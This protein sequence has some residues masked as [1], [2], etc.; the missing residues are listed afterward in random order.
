MEDWKKCWTPQEWAAI[1]G[2][3]PE[4]TAQIREATYADRPL[5]PVHR[6]AGGVPEEVIEAWH[7][8]STEEA[9]RQR[10]SPR[11]N[12][13]NVRLSRFSTRIAN[14]PPDFACVDGSD[15]RRY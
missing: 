2:S 5:N 12:V 10:R 4:E 1:L 8:G 6:A 14:T 13:I 15:N 3:G 11:I 7:S 9:E